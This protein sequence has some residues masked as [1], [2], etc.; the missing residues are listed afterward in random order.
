[1]RITI[2]I[3]Q[4]QLQYQSYHQKQLKTEKYSGLAVAVAANER[5]QAGRC[6]VLESSFIGVAQHNLQLYQDAIAMVQK[7]GHPDLFV[8]FT[9]N[10]AWW[11]SLKTS[12]QVKL[13][14]NVRI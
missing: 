4:A 10:P 6:V 12:N 14:L 3:E 2:K 7:F 8:I 11:K 9:C 13:K 1:M 5:H